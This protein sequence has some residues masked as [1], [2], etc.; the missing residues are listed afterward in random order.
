[1]QELS[2]DGIS[3]EAVIAGLESAQ[4]VEDYPEHSR[5][6]CVLCLQLEDGGRRV[7][8]LWGLANRNADVATI[9]TAYRPDPARWTS[10]LMTRRPR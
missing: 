10:D 8:V 6:P 3:L 2:N 7:H 4:V 5:G 9:I 1:M